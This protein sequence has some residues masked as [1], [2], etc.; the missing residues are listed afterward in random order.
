MKTIILRSITKDIEVLIRNELLQTKYTLADKSSDE[1][2]K[3]EINMLRE[4]LKNKNFIIKDLL[5]TIKKIKT[6]SVSVQSVA[7][8]M[9][10]SEAN[11]VPANNSVAI[12][13]NN[14]KEM[15]E[16]Y[17]DGTAVIIEDSILNYII[18]ERL[19][20]KGR[21]VRLHNFRGAT[22]DDMKHHFIPL[23]RKEPGSVIIHA[24]TN[25]APYL[26]SRKIH[27]NLLTLKY[28]VTKNLHNCKV[29]KSTPTLRTD[30]GKAVITVS[31]LTN[32]LLQLDIGI[33]YNRNFN[34]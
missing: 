25:D 8:C 26:S 5:Q 30:D 24:C 2:Y 20:K 27:G 1:I 3:K 13:T 9:S 29:L 10:S 16:K 12:E 31:Q 14:N 4:E 18:Q 15:Q 34:T 32:H 7:S 28:F 21:V 6:K 23:L 17:P 33:I 19:S 11:L 22:V